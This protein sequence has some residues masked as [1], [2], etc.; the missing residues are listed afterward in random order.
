M[1]V[2]NV[3]CFMMI[4]N[5]RQYVNEKKALIRF[6]M[7]EISIGRENARDGVRVKLNNNNTYSGGDINTKEREQ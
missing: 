1:R 4:L 7:S 5:D 3:S 2:Q 6:K